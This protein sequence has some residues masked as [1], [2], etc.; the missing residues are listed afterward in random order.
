M[1]S[2]AP[3]QAEGLAPGGEDYA[4][5]NSKRNSR[6]AG[7]TSRELTLQALAPPPTVGQPS[8]ASCRPSCRRS[9]SGCRRSAFS[10]ACRWRTCCRGATATQLGIFLGYARGGWWGGLIG[11]LCFVAPAFVIMLAPHYGLRHPGRSRRCAR[12]ALYGL[13]P[14]VHRPLRGARS[15]ASAGPSMSTST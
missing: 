13:G 7:A 2:V 6:E 11:G 3:D 4:C 1:T 14:V 10:K 8:W 15:T 5:Q 9:G 12:G